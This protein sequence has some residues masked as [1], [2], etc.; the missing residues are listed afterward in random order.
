MQNVTNE[1]RK[2]CN[3][4]REKIIWNPFPGSQDRAQVLAAMNDWMRYNCIRFRPA[5]NY[6]HI[7]DGG[8]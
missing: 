8:G 2:A 4:I 1:L 3:A 5:S 6:I 7:Q